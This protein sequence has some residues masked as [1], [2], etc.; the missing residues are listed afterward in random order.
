MHD[1][2]RVGN[3]TIDPSE[4]GARCKCIKARE[5]LIVASS[6]ALGRD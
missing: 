1:H 3:P 2:R 5:T 4:G 6:R